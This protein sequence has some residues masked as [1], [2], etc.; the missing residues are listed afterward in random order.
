ME[1]IRRQGMTRIPARE[2]RR[3]PVSDQVGSLS[4]TIQVHVWRS[5]YM[6]KELL[7]G[8]GD[9][10]P[11]HDEDGSQGGQEHTWMEQNPAFSQGLAG[12]VGLLTDP[13]GLLTDPVTNA[14]RF[15]Y[16]FSNLLGD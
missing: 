12:S 3:A 16:P 6:M 5:A 8:R 9:K 13:V 2:V 10:L 14:H 1:A 11:M 15:D 7:P 4:M